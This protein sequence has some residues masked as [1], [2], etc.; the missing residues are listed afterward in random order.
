MSIVGVLFD[1]FSAASDEEAAAV[2]DRVGGPG[3]Q[4]AIGAPA[5][6]R[7]GIFG[8]K[9]Q[10]AAPATG[11]FQEAGVFDT[12]A[13]NGIDPVVQLGTL[14]ELLTGRSFDDVMDD[15]R[16]GQALADR[17]GGERLVLTLTEP[18]S[19]ALATA[20]DEA[21]ERVAIPWSET[22]EFWNA[23]DPALLA[24]FLK[25]LAGLARRSKASGQ[26]LYCWVCV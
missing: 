20:S 19:T 3:S 22:E 24:G 4:A 6:P 12:V 18:L 5:E 23:A 1:Y 2:I 13:G 7:R 17:D 26:G 16:S 11:T 21:L 15:P 9:R 8:R 25:D 10:P 14:E